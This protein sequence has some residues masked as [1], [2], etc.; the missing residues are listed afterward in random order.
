MFIGPGA[1]MPD[2]ALTAYGAGQIFLLNVDTTCATS[3]TVN[4]DGNGA[5]TITQPNGS[6]APT[7][8]L[9]AGQAQLIWFDGTVMRL[10][11]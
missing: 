8:A 3:C 7:G 6:T 4:I 2:P 1:D 5:E 11:Y 10:M 9:I